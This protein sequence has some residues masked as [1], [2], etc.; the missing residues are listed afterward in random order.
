MLNLPQG[1]FC[2]NI[3]NMKEDII[4]IKNQAI[5]QI[6]DVKSLDELEQIRIDLF[7]RSGKYKVASKEIKDLKN[8]EK[9]RLEL[10]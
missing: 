6:S 1:G 7:G 9:D 4:N 3:D 5:A 10:F 8:E 2:C